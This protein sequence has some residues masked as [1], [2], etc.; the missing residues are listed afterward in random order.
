M[1]TSGLPT[2]LGV[3]MERSTLLSVKRRHSAAVTYA[4]PL[5]PKGPRMRL[6]SNSCYENDLRQAAG[7]VTVAFQLGMTLST[8]QAVRGL[9]ELTQVNCGEENQAQL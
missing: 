1:L 9:H 7:P 6:G 5:K 3:V 2:V 4:R 8:P